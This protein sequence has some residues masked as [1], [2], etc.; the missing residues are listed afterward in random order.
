MLEFLTLMLV[1]AGLAHLWLQLLNRIL[2]QVREGPL[3]NGAIQLSLLLIVVV[4]SVLLLVLRDNS[5][6]N[7]ALMWEP[8]TSGARVLF[9]TFGV[10][11]LVGLWRG[12]VWLAD[13]LGPSRRVRTH[14]RVGIVTIPKM[15]AGR[16]RLPRLFGPL[17]TTYDLELVERELVVPAMA[18]EFDGLTVAQVADVHYDPRIVPQ[19]YYEALARVVASTQPDIVVFTG[20]FVNHPKWIRE[21]I[22]YHAAMKGRLATL[23]VLGNHDYWT[24]PTL[25][26]DECR[27]RGLRPMHNHRWPLERAGRRL[28]VAGTDE[29]WG[30]A[31]TPWQALMRKNPG[32]AVVLLSHTPQNAHKAARH[33]ANLILS[34]HTHGGQYCLPLVG[35]LAVPSLLGHRYVHG[36]YRLGEECLL[37]VS[38]GIGSSTDR[39]GRL[40][41]RL[42]CPPEVIIYTLRAPYADVA[43]PAR[44]KEAKLPAGAVPMPG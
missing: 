5:A 42:L 30:G 27:R 14:D 28:I 20:D 21:S 7:S 16:P 40:A 31:R 10:V 17:E 2:L 29:P 13:R 38:R 12:G 8:T 41:G 25:V 1:V 6:V 35:P 24:N 15:P 37:S 23:C 11:W 34:G 39:E 26:R 36:V 19:G 44:A 33:G 32:D 18:A 3:K 4:P 43:V 22:E 9:A